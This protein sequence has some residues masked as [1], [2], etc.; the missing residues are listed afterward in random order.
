[1]AGRETTERRATM[2]AKRDNLVSKDRHK[3]EEVLPLDTPYTLAV[4]PCN[5]CNFKCR[6]CAMQYSGETQRYQKQ[7]MPLSLFMKIVDDL[8]AFPHKLKVLRIS[9]QGEPLL[10]RDIAEMIR[11]A[12]EREVA[13]FIE[14]V[15]NGSRLSPELNERLIQSGVDRIRISIEAV[16]E[17]GYYEMA[18]AKISLDEFLANIRDLHQRSG[19]ACEIYV[20]TVD[21]AVDTEEKEQ[22]FYQLFENICDRIWI[23]SVI[24][25]WSDW[26]KLGQNF[27]LNNVG[28]HGQELQ[29]VR[30]CPYPFYSL[31]INPDG[32]VT[33]CCADWRRKLVLGDLKEQSMQE[34]WNGERLRTFWADMLSGGK[35]RYEM[36]RK[37]ELPMH[38][39]NDNIDAYAAQILERLK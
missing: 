38:D 11:Y 22:R 13:D 12:K 34:I 37:C 5:L 17:E 39:C 9:G 23:D 8:R 28:M 20:K 26:D 36:C 31:I 25:L 29:E 35:D 16:S 4:D 14:I 10:N 1:M 27:E 33:A 3:L 15:T 19:D 32:E 24:P 18:G 6:F 2:K 21:A 30:I 7:M